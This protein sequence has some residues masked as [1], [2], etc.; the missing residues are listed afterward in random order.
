MS[1]TLADVEKIAELARLDLTHEEKVQY[2]EQLSAVLDHV[3]MLNELDLTHVSPTTHAV[4]RKN[5]MRKDAVEPSLPVDEVLFN[6]P[7]Q[8]LDQFLIQ[9]VLDE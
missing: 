2:G 5:I 8:A 7:R 4:A 6:A 1:L 9:A 3:A